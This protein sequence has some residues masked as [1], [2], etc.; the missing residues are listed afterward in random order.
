MLSASIY[1]LRPSDT[2]GRSLGTVLWQARLL[3]GPF[4]GWDPRMGGVKSDGFSEW[5]WGE[6]ISGCLIFSRWLKPPTSW[7]LF[8]EHV[9]S[10]FWVDPWAIPPSGR[11]QKWFGETLG[12]ETLGGR[13]PR[14]PWSADILELWNMWN[15]PFHIDNWVKDGKSQRFF[16]TWAFGC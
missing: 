16:W 6:R 4:R 1:S 12:T 3:V 11:I 9:L 13:A 7:M 10:S 2:A 15:Q 8:L 5:C 14:R